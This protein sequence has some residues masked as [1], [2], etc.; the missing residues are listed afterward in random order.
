METANE[1]CSANGVSGH[2]W[3]EIVEEELRN[4]VFSGT[5]NSTCTHDTLTGPY[6]IKST[7][8]SISQSSSGTCAWFYESDDSLRS[9]RH[10]NDSVRK[11]LRVQSNNCT[12]PK[13]HNV[14]PPFNLQNW[15]MQIKDTSVTSK[16]NIGATSKISNYLRP[17]LSTISNKYITQ[18]YD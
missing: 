11:P 9:S 14:Y 8:Y 16:K 7:R 6:E 2:H 17:E 13:C 12:L 10:R 1:E 18:P 15:E 5:Y 4:R 3:H